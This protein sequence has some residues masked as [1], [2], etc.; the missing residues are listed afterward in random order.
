MA[1]IVDV[2]RG[3]PPEVA[4]LARD[5]TVQLRECDHEALAEMR[6]VLTAVRQMPATPPGARRVLRSG[7]E[8]MRAMDVPQS[9][10]DG[11][12]A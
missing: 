12:S 8:L 10:P 9:R 7:A 4:S 11:S 3:F 2:L 1:E 5:L 6:Q